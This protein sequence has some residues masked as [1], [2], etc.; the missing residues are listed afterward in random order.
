MVQVQGS[1]TNGENS[2]SV[3]TASATG[4]SHDKDEYILSDNTFKWKMSI[5][6]KWVT[7]YI[8][9]SIRIYNF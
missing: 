2:A 5:D 6:I 3:D 7:G 4:T 9:P 8:K 1:K